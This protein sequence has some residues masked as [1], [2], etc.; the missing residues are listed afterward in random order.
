MGTYVMREKENCLE[1]VVD[2]IQNIIIIEHN[3]SSF[4]K[5]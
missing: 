2:N 1:F 4:I 5:V 3:F